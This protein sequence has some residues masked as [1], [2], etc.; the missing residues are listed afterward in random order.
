[1]RVIELFSGIGSQYKA[2]KNVIDDENEIEVIATCDWDFNAIIAYD[3]IHNGPQELEGFEDLSDNEIN[4]E[5]LQLAISSNGKVPMSDRSKMSLSRETKIRLL[6]AIDRTNNLVDITNVHYDQIDLNVDLMTYSFPCQDLS[7]AGNWH[8]NAGGINRD[9]HNRSSLLWQVE[10]ILKEIDDVGRPL[11]K[12]LLMENVT[13]IKSNNHINNFVEWINVL[14]ELGYESKH[15]DLLATDFGSPQKRKRTFMI[16]VLSKNNEELNGR[17]LN[18]FNQLNNS[19]FKD[20]YPSLNN[21]TVADI[22]REN[23]N[24]DVYLNEALNSMPNDTLSRR[25]IYDRNLHIDPNTQFIPTITTKQDRHP[26]SG[27]LDFNENG[28]YGLDK[29][30]F[31]YL[32]PRE[33]FMLMGFTENDFQALMDNNFPERKTDFFSRDKLHRMAGNSISVNVLEGIFSLVVEL[34]DMMN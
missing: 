29:S 17:V 32:T 10:R 9:A 16:S 20:L 22:L 31:R 18:L 27:V 23:Y 7:L 28:N 14:D 30:K 33:C 4:K 2:L 5:I 13:A 24:N 12:I 15:F 6:S 3:I 26:N 1:M 25:A 8:G 34:L 21:F 11:P 19:N